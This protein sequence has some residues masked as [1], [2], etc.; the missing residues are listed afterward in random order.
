MKQKGKTPPTPPVTKQDMSYQTAGASQPIRI[1]TP[2]KTPGDGPL[3]VIVYFHGGGWVIADIDTYESSAMA[4]AQKAN[5]IVASA[6][7]RHAPEA[8]FPAAH[9]D[10]FT[11]YQWVLKNAQKFG[12]DPRRVAVAGESAGGN[13]AANVAIMARDKQVQQPVHMLLVYPVAGSDMNTESYQENAN[14]KPLNKFAM[15]WFVQHALE[16]KDTNN[17]MINLVAANLMNL[18]P[19]TIITAEIDLLRS[20][21]QQL[22]KKLEAAGVETSYENYEGVTHEFFGMA[23]VVADAAKAQDFAA[24]ELREAF[25]R[26]G[27]DRSRR[28]TASDVN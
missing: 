16:P 27:D 3:P 25:E 7:Y 26:A 14:A 17:P 21:G 9:E 6:E 10:A 4:L 12:G 13:L 8:K 1:Y 11:A 22:A 18:A 24:R 28:A 20:E 2:T 19:A 5:A 23:A 15:A